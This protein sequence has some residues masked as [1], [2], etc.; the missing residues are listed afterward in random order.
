MRNGISRMRKNQML[1]EPIPVPRAVRI[2]R[3]LALAL[4]ISI[5]LGLG[6]AYRFGALHGLSNP[7]AFAEA[8]RG[9]GAWGYLWFILAYALLQ[10]FGVPGT[11]FI[12]AAPL[13]WPWPVAFALSMVGTM[14]ASVIGFSFARFVARDW[15]SARV[16]ERLRKYEAALERQ[17]F[18]T[19]LVLRLI[20]WMPQ[21][22]HFFLGV[23]RVR[24]STHFWGSLLGYVPPLFLV[25]YLGSELFDASGKLTARA[26]PVTGALLAFS[27]S[28]IFG[29]RAYDKRQRATS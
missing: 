19:V 17:A 5:A 23:S 28:L 12:V 29:L 25:S 14:C 26:W 11:V 16:P 1:V 3:L 18:R 8:V 2:A 22:L 10:P 7:H 6:L 13:I 27:V 15:L 4:G 21:V 9:L 24:F 20:F